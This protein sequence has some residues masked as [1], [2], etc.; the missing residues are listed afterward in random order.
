MIE[1]EMFQMTFGQLWEKTPEYYDDNDVIGK[2]Q[3]RH[4]WTC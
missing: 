2:I 1:T 4:L 3:M